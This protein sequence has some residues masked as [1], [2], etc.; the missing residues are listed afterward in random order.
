MLESIVQRT[1]EDTVEAEMVVAPL[2]RATVE[3]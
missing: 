1:K 2:N 3:V